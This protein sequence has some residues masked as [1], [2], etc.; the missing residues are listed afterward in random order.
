VKTA[1]LFILFFLVTSADIFSQ[2]SILEKKVKIDNLE[3]PVSAI[4]KEIGDKGGFTFSYGQD[5]PRDRFV[6]LKNSKQTVGQFLDEIFKKEIYCVEYGN[7]LII[8]QKPIMPEVYTVRGK[9]IDTETKEPLPGVTVCIP[10]TKPLIGTVSDQK[11][12]FQIN[13][14]SG[15]DII[16]LSCI[17]YESKAIKSGQDNNTNFELN[18]ENHELSEVEIVYYKKPKEEYI[19]SAVSSIPEEQLEKVQLGGVED[20]LQGNTAG[21]HV[22]RNSGI[23][24]SSLQVKVRG[25]N[26]LISSDPEYFLDGIYIQQTLLYA[27]SPHD[28]ESIEVL[29]DASCTAKYG[30]SAGNGVV[31]LHSKKSNGKR[32]TAKLDYYVGQQHVWKE[33]DLMT[34]SEFLEYSELVRPDTILYEELDSTYETDWIDLIFHTAKTE[35]F[36]FSVSGGSKKSDFYVSSGYYKQ[37]A[38]IKELD[39]TRYSFKVKSDHTINQGFKIGQDVSLAHVNFKGLKEGCFLNDYKNPILGA[40]CMLPLKSPY[41]SADTWA[42]SDAIIINPYD[43]AELKNNSRKIYSVLTSLNSEVSLMPNINYIMKL[44][45]EIYFQDNTSFNR[46]WPYRIADSGDLIYGNT[47][48]ILDLSFD[49]HHALHYSASFSGDHSLDATLA[50]EFGRNKNEWIPISRNTYDKYLSYIADTVNPDNKSFEN[51][52]SAS[53]FLHHAYTGSVQYKYKNRYLVDLNIRKETVGFYSDHNLKKISDIYPSVSVGWIFTKEGF[54]SQKVLDYGKIRYGLGM[55]GNSPRIN[56]SFYADMM[57]DMEYIYAIYYDR[58]V[59]NSMG[60]RQTN[61]QFYREIINSRNLGLDLGLFDNRLFISVDYFNNHLNM[62]NK[63]P[64]DNSIAIIQV[65]NQMYYFGIEDLPVAEINNKGFELEFRYKY[66][67]RKLDWDMNF[68]LTHLNNKIID[69]EEN[70]LTS[71]KNAPYEPISINLPGEAAGSFYGYRIERLFTAE[72]C[73]PETG[74]AINQP[75]TKDENGNVSYA[76][77]GAMAGDYKFV[78]INNDNVIDRNDITIIGNPF[79]KFTFG[80]FYNIQFLN[81]DFSIF[82]QGTYGNDIFN[83]IKYWLYNPYGLSNWTRDIENSYRAPIYSE[84]GELI[85]PGHTNTT[86]HR[87]SYDDPNRNLRV[88]DFYVE[89]GSYIRLKNIQ[90]GYTINPGLTKKVHIQKFRIFICSQN[91]FTITNYSGLDPEVGGWGIDSGIYP[92]P[93]V[94][95]AGLNLEF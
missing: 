68:N 45:F 56:Y 7:K 81:F 35:D 28:I 57:R 6:A 46:K 83:A 38:I 43:D 36:H 63:Y 88:S 20:A 58:K 5:I 70:T 94:Y 79:P 91:L 34:A 80:M 39:L 47:Y 51:L 53:E 32:T 86:L 37:S 13:V 73:D 89:D 74:E 44:G 9:V 87:V 33:P 11:G 61:E 77:P 31:L 84:S 23:P 3:G 26:S 65:I 8:I 66:S 12:Y 72:D 92:Q 30:S 41:D 59:T 67:S 49:W 52:R 64:I 55:A 76:Q 62:G 60:L 75:Y 1:Y 22:V 16:Q 71:I 85:D 54:F 10:G 25:I 69:I 93:R 90:L 2:T 50:F 24:G 19:N 95:L 29:K 42:A 21:V 78:N 17:G 14:L 18:P 48:N 15:G 40:M 27:L 82:F 4:L